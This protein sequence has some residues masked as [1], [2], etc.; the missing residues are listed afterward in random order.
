MML[1]ELLQKAKEFEQNTEIKRKIQKG[2]AQLKKFLK[3]YP[4]REKPELIESLTTEQIYNPGSDDY[5]FLWIEHKTRDLGAITV[6]GAKVYL[7]AIEE[8]ERF[9]QLLRTVIDEKIPISEKIDKEYGIKGFGGDKHIIKKILYCYF[10]ES[11][12]PIFNTNHMEKFCQ[13]LNLDYE[14]RALQEYH[15]PYGNLSKGEKFELLNKLLLEFKNKF[16]PSWENPLFMRFLYQIFEVKEPPK[17][18]VSA[19]LHRLG[20]LFEPQSEQEVV[21]L[22]SLLHRELDFPYILKFQE[23]FPDVIVLDKNRNP[24]K[25]EIEKFASDFIAHEHDPNGCDYIICWE[26]DLVDIPEKFPEI[27]SLKDYLEEY[28]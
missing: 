8:I 18:R 13:K 7:N 27:I 6:Y 3:A 10:K 12:L 20:L 28:E 21:Y 4:F 25:I 16:L 24:K 26:N 2:K 23:T 9:K 11:I 14:K 19:P 15:K 17:K 22:F 5:F 1:D